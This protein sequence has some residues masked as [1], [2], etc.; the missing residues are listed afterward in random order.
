MVSYE[1]M[2]TAHAPA[3]EQAVVIYCKLFSDMVTD[4]LCML[5]RKE[6]DA[7]DGFSCDGCIVESTSRRP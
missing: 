1:V 7:R 3:G 2:R 5:R 6:L 4:H